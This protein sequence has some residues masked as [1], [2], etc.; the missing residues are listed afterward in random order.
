MNAEVDILEESVQIPFEG[1]QL[2]GVLAYP[3]AG[4]PCAAVL[5]VGPHP[6][7]GGRLDNNVVRNVAR[8]LSEQRQLTLRFEFRDA[9]TTSALMD[10]FWETGHAPDDPHRA[11]EARAAFAFLTRVWSGPVFL[12]GYSFGASLLGQLPTDRVAGL[13]LVSPT[14]RQHDFSTLAELELRKL[15]ITSD[16]DF[17]T[18][19]EV[20]RAWFN[21]VV[22]PRLLV[23][24]PAAEHFYRGQEDQIVNEVIR[25]QSV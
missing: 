2:R 6:Y 12:L 19:L 13:V 1:G 11:D 17:A 8:G 15:V 10:A 5:L 18:P 25:W 4:A 9:Q 16:R 22:E 21:G 3:L 23:I 7:M 20:T 14:L 24:I